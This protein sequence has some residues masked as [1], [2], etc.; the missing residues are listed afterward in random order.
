[1]NDCLFCKIIS[2]E[3]PAY[4]VYEDEL[5]LGFLDIQP[6]NP[7]HV[8]IAPKVHFADMLDIDEKYLCA[9]GEAIPKVARKV[10]EAVGAK[11]FNVGVNNGE[12][13]GQLIPHLHFHIMPRFEGDGHQLFKGKEVSSNDL[14]DLAAK[15][16]AV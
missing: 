9:I 8:L 3:L 16:N 2:G 6:V 10:L 11:D 5:V 12:L 1:M 7:G 15:L 14:R 13:A 4:I